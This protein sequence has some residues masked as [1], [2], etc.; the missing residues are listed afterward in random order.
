MNTYQVHKMLQ[1]KHEDDLE[2]TVDTV[3]LA[4]RLSNPSVGQALD[5]SVREDLE[6]HFGHSF[7]NVRIHHN[8]QSHEMTQSV[9]A[10]AF[11]TGQDIY[12]QQGTYDPTSSNGREL[13]AHELTHVVQNK[14][15]G[16][17][18]DHGKSLGQKNDAAELEATYVSRNLFHPMIPNPI[19][20]IPDGFILK[21]DDEKSPKSIQKTTA[22]GHELFS[23]LA[24]IYELTRELTDNKSEIIGP[25]GEVLGLN[26]K[27]LSAGMYCEEAIST[28][29]K[30]AISKCVTSTADSMSKIAKLMGKKGIGSLLS[31]LSNFQKINANLKIASESNDPAVYNHAANEAVQNAVSLI[32]DLGDL[33]PM[34]KRIKLGFKLAAKTGKLALQGGESMVNKVNEW[35][36]SQHN[37][38]DES[39]N[40]QNSSQESGDRGLHME[41]LTGSKTVGALSAMINAE[42]LFTYTVGKFSIMKTKNGITHL[43]KDAVSATTSLIE[44]IAGPKEM[45]ELDSVT[46]VNP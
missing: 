45:D 2:S 7:E 42:I 17:Q 1:R 32:G 3:R 12:F 46:V 15:F 38:E 18:A 26:G 13:L 41:E 11:T 4:T 33:I 35:S 31:T 44:A 24:K 14:V 16:S 27:L 8:A 40:S 39:G 9:N 23:D 34:P 36:V 28:G 10:V 37:F 25:L 19:N 20:A 43:H 6:P 22:K 29:D 30:D 21:K 5:T